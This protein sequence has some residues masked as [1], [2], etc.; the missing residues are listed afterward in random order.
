MHVW[1]HLRDIDHLRRRAEG[2]IEDARGSKVG[3][4]AS[5]GHRPSAKDAHKLDLKDGLQETP[6]LVDMSSMSGK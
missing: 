3:S 5:Y 6:A 2:M 1:Q 4:A